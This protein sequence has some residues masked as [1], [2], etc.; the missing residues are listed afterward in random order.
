MARP[1]R[2]IRYTLRDPRLLMKIMEHPGTG[3]PYTVRTLAADASV[4]RGKI[5]RLHCGKQAS[6]PMDEAHAVAETLGVAI[7]V[8]FAP[9]SSPNQDTPS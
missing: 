6:L 5:E 4:S 2:P 9:P 1:S 8:L 3:V 7:L